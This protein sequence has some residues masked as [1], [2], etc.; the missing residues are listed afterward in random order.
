MRM[1]DATTHDSDASTRLLASVLVALGCVQSLAL[2]LSCLHIPMTA[3]LAW[4]ALFASVGA[5]AAYSRLWP[6][7]GTHEG[8]AF[9]WLAKGVF[10]VGLTGYAILWGAAL[11]QPDWSSD[12]NTYHIPTLFFWF[13]SGYIH[14]I[15]QSTS[16]LFSAWVNGYPKAIEAQAFVLV[17]ATQSLRAANVNNLLFL[18]AGSVGLYVLARR[19]TASRASSLVAAALYL[20]LPLNAGQV[21]TT[22]VD[23]S[24]AAC[25]IL[26]SAMLAVTFRELTAGHLR[27]RTI[28]PLG[29]AAGL[30]LGAK[31][32][33]LPIYGMAALSLLWAWVLRRRELRASSSPLNAMLKLLLACLVSLLI[34]GFWYARDFVHTGSPLHPVGLSIGNRII[35]PG[36]SIVE[37]T[38]EEINTPPEIRNLAA[39]A[40]VVYTWM[41]G[42]QHWPQSIIGFDMRLGGLGYIWIL[43]CV[44]AL[45]WAM[46]CFRREA[47]SARL[48]FFS[49]LI[50]NV[51]AFPFMPTNWWSRF[52]M[53][54]AGLGLAVFAVAIDSVFG[55]KA[56]WVRAWVYLCLSVWLVESVIVVSWRASYVVPEGW[57][58]IR[59]DGV[60]AFS[61]FN[62]PSP[63]PDYIFPQFKNTEFERVLRQGGAVAIGPS[64]SPPKDRV[65]GL[66]CYPLKER[67]LVLLPAKPTENDMAEL[68]ERKPEYLVWDDQLALPESLRAQVR[69]A[70]HAGGF[71]LYR[72]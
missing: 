23:A 68:L 9:S 5:G 54:I 71:N 60:K 1:L 27:G 30:M 20:L 48:I 13:K 65:V 8:D 34:G 42:F 40:K 67:T 39:P 3:A 50:I 58:A 43:G 52:T 12:G 47:G 17:C 37:V 70:A 45:I 15:P 11:F 57:K 38:K 14:W 21:A 10:A 28:L 72:L 33:A 62:P 59:R 61:R 32:V 6:K 55:S 26:L 36:L 46:M 41:Q 7:A 19:L 64:L 53:W 56:R 18:A 49:L 51:V 25:V 16:P 4:L 66:F 22:Y 63:A 29:I 44:P 2:I 69:L 35:F 31:S 24:F